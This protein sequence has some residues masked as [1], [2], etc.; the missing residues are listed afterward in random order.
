VATWADV[1]RIALSLPGASETKGT[2]LGTAVWSVNK[3]LFVWER[4]LRKADL[5]A[6]GA[7]A[8]KGPILGART[9]DLEMKEVLLKSDPKVFFTT[10]HFEGYPAVLIRLDEIGVKKLRDVIEE[11][12]LSR[13]GKRAVAEYLREAGR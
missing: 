11:A 12:W 1:S 3:R 10:P 13:A 8:P 5:A 7:K 4:P 2:S 6:L 9:A